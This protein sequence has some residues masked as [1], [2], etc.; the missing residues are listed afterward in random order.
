MTN[1]T[2]DRHWFKTLHLPKVLKAL[3]ASLLLVGCVSQPKVYV[4][5]EGNDTEKHRLLRELD[6]KGFGTDLSPISVPLQ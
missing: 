2:A 5:F 3:T 4:Y 6:M 1:G